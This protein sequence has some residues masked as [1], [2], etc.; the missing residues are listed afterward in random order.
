MVKGLGYAIESMMAI[1]IILGFALGAVQVSS[2]DQDWSDYQRHIAA[3]DITYSMQ[4]SGK[5]EN[6]VERG[7]MGSF[8][9]S[10]ATISERE[11]EVSGAVSNLPLYELSVGY[12]TIPENRFDENIVEA[13]ETCDEDDLSELYESV[14]EG[15]IYRTDGGLEDEYETRLYLANTNPTGLEFDTSGYDTLWVDNGTEC[16]FADE[17]GPFHL[18][19]IFYWGD[20]ENSSPGDHFD[21]KDADIDSEEALFYNATQAQSIKTTLREG[22]NEINTDVSL[23]VVDFNE[24]ESESHQILIFPERESLDIIDSNQNAIESHMVEGSMLFLM[25]PE[26]GDMNSD[27]L[28]SLNFEWVDVSYEDNSYD[29]GLTEARFSQERDSINLETFYRA[30]DSEE[31]D[32]DDLQLRPPGN[33][34]SNSSSRIEPGRTLYSSSQIYDFSEWSFTEDNMNYEGSHSDDPGD[35]DDVHSGTADFEGVDNVDFI[36]AAVGSNC[37]NYALVF[38]F[39][40]DGDYD[41]SVYLNG[42]RVKQNNIEYAIDLYGCGIEGECATF[43]AVGQGNVELFPNTRTFDWVSGESRV[44]MLG[45]QDRY[46]ET[47]RKLISST[48]HWLTEGDHTFE[49]REDPSEVDTSAKGSVYNQVYMPYK[50][51]LRWSE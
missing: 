41:S 45:Y 49:G 43:H 8:Q 38:D 27:I 51:D 3:Q 28:S 40:G 22:L 23:D 11:M 17:D 5:L 39:D 32:L 19:D 15:E 26:E 25:N 31:V 4:S 34:I 2:P 1:I 42:E 48:I 37:D 13:G 14:D 21:F 33:V 18:N 46:N 50:I 44:G 36:N 29:G 47:Q 12:F 35:C 10:A 6:F 24:I 30:Q 7:E 20:D 9:D 16:Q